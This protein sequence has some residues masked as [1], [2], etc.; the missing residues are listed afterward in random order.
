MCIHTITIHELLHLITPISLH[1]S[2]INSFDY[3]KPNI[4]KHLWLYEGVI[5]YFTM[6]TLLKSGLISQKNFLL[7]IKDKL[8]KSS[9]L[10]PRI[11]HNQLQTLQIYN[12]LL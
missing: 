12:L 1:S 4:S 7:E 11:Q 5:E 10:P 3:N 8:L 2:S 9:T 6:L